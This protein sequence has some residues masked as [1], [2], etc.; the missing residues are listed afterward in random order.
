MRWLGVLI[1]LP[2]VVLVV[3]CDLLIVTGA[4]VILLV[5]MWDVSSRVIVLLLIGSTLIEVVIFFLYLCFSEWFFCLHWRLPLSDSRFHPT[6]K[7]VIGEF[8]VSSIL[9]VESIKHMWWKPVFGSV[10][11][12]G[13][14]FNSGLLVMSVRYV[15]S[16]PGGVAYFCECCCCCCCCW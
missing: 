5:A 2:L 11:V 4:M 6:V 9:V 15:L 16:H 13:C 1:L 12:A 3:V 7:F 14:S 10:V 8:V